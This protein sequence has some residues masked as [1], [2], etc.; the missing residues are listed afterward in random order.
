MNQNST[1]ALDAIESIFKTMDWSYERKSNPNGVFTGFKL[2]KKNNA[3]IV[4]MPDDNGTS[5]LMGC[6]YHFTVPK[7]Q[8]AKIR[9]FFQKES[10]DINGLTIQ[11]D[12]ARGVRLSTRCWL[13]TLDLSPEDLVALIEPYFRAMMHTVTSLYPELIK[14]LRHQERIKPQDDFHLPS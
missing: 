8:L 6:S 3:H 13:P 10:F 12:P 14:L 1:Q 11:F 2:D 7:G 9:R 5:L 4:I